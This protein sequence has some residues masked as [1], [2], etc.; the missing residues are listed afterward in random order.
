MCDC[1][2][3]YPPSMSHPKLV[4]AFLSQLENNVKFKF[5]ARSLKVSKEGLLIFET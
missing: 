3:K 1:F 5:Y 2:P 4:T